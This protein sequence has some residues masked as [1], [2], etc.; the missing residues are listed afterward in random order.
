M[1][2]A[3]PKGYSMIE[4]TLGIMTFF[5]WAFALASLSRGSNFAGFLHQSTEAQGRRKAP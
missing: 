3:L 4:S 5:E 2:D 1:L